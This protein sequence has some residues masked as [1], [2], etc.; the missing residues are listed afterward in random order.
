MNTSHLP[1]PTR[2]LTQ[3]FTIFYP[4]YPLI[5]RS[6]SSNFFFYL[7]LPYK[8]SRL[9]FLNSTVYICDVMKYCGDV[10]RLSLVFEG[11]RN[12]LL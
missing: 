9:F 6:C 3:F 2:V 11:D 10:E 4:L 1:S 8:C 5:A 7:P 12:L